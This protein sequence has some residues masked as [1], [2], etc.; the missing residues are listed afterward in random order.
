MDVTGRIVGAGGDEFSM[1]PLTLAPGETRT[2]DVSF[3]SQ[4]GGL[5][6]AALAVTPC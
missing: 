1:A 6:R 5:K 2:Q 4:R 3:H